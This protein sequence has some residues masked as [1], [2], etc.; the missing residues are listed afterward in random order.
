[1][2]E[3]DTIHKLAAVLR[4]ELGGPPLI[5]A[6]L[7][8]HPIE[9]FL[10]RPVDAVDAHGKH[11]LIGVGDRVLRTHLGMDGSW[12][13]YAPHAQWQRPRWQA[14]VVLAHA[15]RTFVCFRAKEAEVLERG[16]A[17]ARGFFRRQGPDLI[18]TRTEPHAIAR[19]ARD[20]LP[21][22]TPLCDVL[23]D[24]R[25]GAGIGNV[26]KSE[27]LFLAGRDPRD[28]LRSIDDA[29]LAGI[30]DRAQRLLLRNLRPGPRRTR[31]SRPLTAVTDLAEDGSLWVYGRW[32]Q[33]CAVCRAGI[34]YARLG[35][36]N[37]S[38]YW[39]PQCQPPAT[40]S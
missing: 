29:D 23:L 33:P 20:R 18:D 17:R 40:R 31:A 6:R 16:G 7:A 10:S 39:C 30:F 12:H 22:G 35:R 13:R 15:E 37:R 14:T 38:T 4:A 21:G 25:I 24:Q 11:L 8:G 1:V 32:Q 34:R 3:G 5:E 27:L 9:T 19:R 26:Y 28:P 2:P 36:Q